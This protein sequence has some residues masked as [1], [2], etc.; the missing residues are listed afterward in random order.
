MKKQPKIKKSA[1]NKLIASTHL[2]SKIW[3]TVVALMGVMFG[4]SM[5]IFMNSFMNGVNQTQDDLAFSTLAHVRIYNEND[6]RTYNPVEDFF[7]NP[8]TLFNIRNKKSIQYTDGIKN[9]AQVMSILEKQPE[10]TGVTPQL[11]FSV[12]FRNGSKKINGAIS[13][14]EVATENQM[15]GIGDK[16][17]SGDWNNLDFQ[18]SGIVIGTVLAQNLNINLNDNINILTPEGVSKNLIVVGIVETS[19]IRATSRSIC[20]TATVL[21]KRFG[22]CS[23]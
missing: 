3:Q 8:G 16:V 2:T 14:V 17:V 20:A 7:T 6:R 19:I 12:F 23:R 11:N 9:T 13:G 21:P 10:I 18:K 1:V 4:V 15:F 22:V 5:Y